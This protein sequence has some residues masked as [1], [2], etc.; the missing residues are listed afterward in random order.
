MHSLFN[1]AGG[2]IPTLGNGEI[3]NVPT[4][5]ITAVLAVLVTVYSVILF[6]KI[7]ISSIYDLFKNKRL[8]NQE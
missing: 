6:L 2:V 8:N 7:D 3:W 4:I 5:I 1:F